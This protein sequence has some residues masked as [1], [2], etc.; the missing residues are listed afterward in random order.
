MRHD[1]ENLRIDTVTGRRRVLRPP[2][3][4]LCLLAACAGA[5]AADEAPPRLDAGQAAAPVTVRWLETGQDGRVSVE[6]I[7]GVDYQRLELRLLVTG[8]GGPPAPMMLSGGRRG[9]IRRAAW[10]L[11]KTPRVTPRLQVILEIAGHRLGRTVAAPAPTR[12]QPPPSAG[13]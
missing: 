13:P 2:G 8:A 1:V 9:E 3:A 12:V 10:Y 11:A 4:W 5:A 7:P 6:V